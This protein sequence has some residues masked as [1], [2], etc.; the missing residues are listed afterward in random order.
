MNVGPESSDKTPKR[1]WFQIKGPTEWTEWFSKQAFQPADAT[2]TFSRILT[3]VGDGEKLRVLMQI[4][5][6][7]GVDGV[8]VDAL[9]FDFSRVYHLV[10]ADGMNDTPK[11]RCCSCY[12]FVFLNFLFVFLFLFFVIASVCNFV[13]VTLP[14]IPFFVVVLVLRGNDWS[15]S[16][17]SFFFCWKFFLCCVSP[18][19]LNFYRC[20]IG[21]K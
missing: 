1:V 3:D 5:N 15:C 21:P 10:Y 6:D 16:I 12:T 14:G 17:Y 19:L 7:L 20:V 8:G 11:I 13:W 4:N 9:Y 18:R 2:Y